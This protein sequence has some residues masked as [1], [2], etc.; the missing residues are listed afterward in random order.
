MKKYIPIIFFI[1]TMT[2]SLKG[3]DARFSQYLSAPLLLNPALTGIFNQDWR[4]I[5]NYRNQWKTIANS[6]YQ[7]TAFSIDTK[8]IPFNQDALSLGLLLL[9]DKAGAID[10]QMNMAYLSIGYNKH[11]GRLGYGNHFVSLGFQGGYVSTRMD[12]SKIVVEHQGIPFL[13]N[14]ENVQYPEVA[15]GG[16]WYYTQR[17]LI[18]HVGAAFYHLNTPIN[19]FFR[20]TATLSPR[21]SYHVGAEIT[22]NQYF[23]LLPSIIHQRQGRANETVLGTYLG[24]K[25]NNSDI[26]V[27]SWYRLGDAIILG[28]R[29]SVNNLTLLVSYDTN[30]SVLSDVSQGFGSLELGVLYS[31]DYG[32]I[33]GGR[34]TF[35]CPT[36]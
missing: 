12:I 36:F 15:T 2:S 34:K 4:V 14:Y 3:Q 18:V 10:F 23:T 11:L 7:T 31:G 6:S 9:N 33:G 32:R 25:S 19:S 29:I 35:Q 30:I 1:I 22:L 21:Q 17:E 24:F 20:T 16:L 27:G 26:Y 28:T 8:A 5:G 13:L